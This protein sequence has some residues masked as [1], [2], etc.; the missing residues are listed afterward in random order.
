MGTCTL[1]FF[2]LQAG[3]LS[4]ESFLAKKETVLF[5]SHQ[6]LLLGKRSRQ[7]PAQTYPENPEFLDVNLGLVH[8]AENISP[9]WRW[10]EV[11]RDDLEPV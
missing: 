3:E 10:F 8:L 5:F 1:Q 4:D 9:V 6:R 11:R 2:F 7:Q